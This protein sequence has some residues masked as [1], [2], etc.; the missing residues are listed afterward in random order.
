MKRLRSIA[1]RSASWIAL[2]YGM[3]PLHDA[4]VTTIFLKTGLRLGFITAE[5]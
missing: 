5:G 1:L 4:S 3:G 2:G